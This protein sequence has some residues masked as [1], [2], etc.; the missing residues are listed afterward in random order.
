MEIRY[1]AVPDLS[2]D[3]LILFRAHYN[4]IISVAHARDSVQDVIVVG[5]L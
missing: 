5:K 3:C 1:G 4:E 2:V